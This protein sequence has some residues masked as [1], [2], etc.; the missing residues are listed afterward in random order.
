MS[1]VVGYDVIKS[2]CL[3]SFE[4]KIIYGWFDMESGYG[5]ALNFKLSEDKSIIAIKKRRGAEFNW[6]FVRLA[7]K[8]P[9]KEEEVLISLPLQDVVSIKDDKAIV[10]MGTPRFPPYLAEI[11]IITGDILSILS[12]SILPRGIYFPKVISRTIA[13]I[14]DDDVEVQFFA[15]IPPRFEGQDPRRPFVLNLNGGPICDP[16]TEKDSRELGL[17]LAQKGIG[18]VIVNYRSRYGRPS[19]DIRSAADEKG[20]WKDS[21]IW[22]VVT[23]LLELKNSGIMG[24][25]VLKG[26]SYD[27]KVVMAI[28]LGISPDTKKYYRK[29]LKPIGLV[30]LG[31]DYLPYDEDDT[32]LRSRIT[33][34]DPSAKSIPTVAVHGTED[35]QTPFTPNG[36]YIRE[37]VEKNTRA[38]FLPARN[39][40]HTL[41]GNPDID[42][43]MN[44]HLTKIIIRM[45]LG[46]ADP[47][48]GF[49]GSEL[50]VSIT[51]ESPAG[52]VP[53]GAASASAAA[54]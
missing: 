27:A 3:N 26:A 25:L 22:D 52:T 1:N 8:E 24:D 32:G 16:T 4:E 30:L 18:S 10:K 23:A 38:L 17:E 53:G 13:S 28:A 31:G 7:T 2:L 9:D 44:N 51:K 42:E 5:Y 48:E 45:A 54:E 50:H 21:D 43:F 37:Y 34:E 47:F 36:E 6:E 46:A 11:N 19:E 40:G 41:V 12:K 39:T 20:F 15:T 33:F 29:G 14:A 49:R 35:L